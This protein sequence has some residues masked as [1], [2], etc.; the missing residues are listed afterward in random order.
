MLTLSCLLYRLICDD[1]R[2]CHRKP[3]ALSPASTGATCCRDRVIQ[4]STTTVRN[5][6]CLKQVTEAESE[7]VTEDES[8]QVL[9]A[10]SQQVNGAESQ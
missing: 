9:E 5:V 3:D 10:E 8:E 6:S 1:L 4:Y 7:Q 2:V